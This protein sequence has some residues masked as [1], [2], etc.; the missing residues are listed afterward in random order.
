M[1]KAKTSKS[2]PSQTHETPAIW[3]QITAA[4]F[5]VAGLFVLVALIL[6][7]TGPVGNGLKVLLKG[8]LGAGSYATPVLLIYLA[9]RTVKSSTR[10][11]FTMKFWAGMVSVICFSIIMYLFAN[12]NS[13]I[14]DIHSIDS[15]SNVFVLLFNDGKNS[16][17]SG[18]VL[19]GIGIPLE[20]L[21][22]K[23]GTAILIGLILLVSFMLLTGITLHKIFR[24]LFPFKPKDVAIAINERMN[25]KVKEEETPV[26]K[27]KTPKVQIDIPVDDM[28]ELTEPQVEKIIEALSLDEKKED[29]PKPRH[30]HDMSISDLPAGDLT[31][32]HSHV[33]SKLYD[34]PPISLLKQNTSVSASDV[35]DELRSNAKK[36]IDTLDSFGVEAKVMN[37]SRGPSV[38]RYELQPGSGVK[39]SK[40]A[41][42]S[43]DLAL[44]LAALG[45]RIEAPIPGKAAVG[46]EVP[47]K[48]VSPVLI[49][50]ILT[51]KEFIESKSNLTVCL[52]K[53]IAGAHII[54]D[55]GKMPH[56]LIAG[57]TGSGKSVCV[58]SL[59]I[60]LLYKSTPDQVKLL[61]IDPKVVE[62]RIYNKIPHLLVP[63]VTDPK[64]AA[65]ALNWAVIEMLNR[66][67]LF[68]EQNVRDISGY[69]ELAKQDAS[70][71]AMPHIVI[72]ID[73]LADLMMAAPNEVEDSICRL[74]QMARAAGMHLVIATQRPSVDVLTGTIKANIPSRIAFAV[75][76]QVDS[77]IILDMS[78]AE[79]L[80]GKG[81]M[82]FCPVGIAKPVRIQGCFVSDKEVESVTDYVKR[83]KETSFD[84]N[85]IEQIE[86]AVVEGS[87]GFEKDESAD[88]LLPQAIE[89]VIESGLASA[90]LLQRRLKLG[91]ARAARIIDEME[92]RGI[93]GPFE[94]SKPRQVLITKHQWQEM[95]MSSK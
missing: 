41:N 81:D 51:S 71:E 94:G 55:L 86:N 83:D 3:R 38:T 10:L 7:V 21:L 80:L 90:S 68:A 75:S 74:A 58:N 8:L 82:L 34:Y 95:M 79:K 9:V 42:L 50:E 17:I 76:S 92:A 14:L 49:R 87:K 22:D 52:G 13:K 89:C 29:P 77:R 65:G 91:Y 31:V 11:E 44:N 56:L 93:V 32:K 12:N 72:L 33:Q 60:S 67:K 24:T 15:I 53:D 18:G 27:Q 30:A 59:I 1:K 45:V 43:D 73:E 64:K 63:V 28:V 35:S 4:I 2:S 85:I 84:E 69:N 25:A 88:E 36:L 70:I 66:Y 19:G 47:N 5:I 20:I 6:D 37:I 40:I 54:T 62:L 78:G 46:I 61:M 39:I 23:V 26:L 16:F 48:V 57:A